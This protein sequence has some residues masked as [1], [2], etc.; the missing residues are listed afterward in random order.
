MTGIEPAYSGWEEYSGAAPPTLGQH[1]SYVLRTL[2]GLAD[3]DLERLAA[4]SVIGTRQPGAAQT[5]HLPKLSG[6]DGSTGD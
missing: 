5:E 4:N 3:D 1:T 6:G 2:S